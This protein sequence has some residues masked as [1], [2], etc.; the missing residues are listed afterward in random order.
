MKVKGG[1]WQETGD[2]VDRSSRRMPTRC[3]K[4]GGNRRKTTQS[5]GQTQKKTK[6]N[7]TGDEK[8]TEEKRALV[9]LDADNGREMRVCHT[10]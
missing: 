10:S 4:C 3:A 1:E 2:G 5:G 8:K 9:S 7:T 6:E